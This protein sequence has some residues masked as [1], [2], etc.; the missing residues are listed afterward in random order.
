MSDTGNRSAPI[1]IMLT[2]VAVSVAAFFGFTLKKAKEKR[3]AETEVQA[4]KQEEILAQQETERRAAEKQAAQ[5]AE[6]ADAMR[7]RHLITLVEKATAR[8][9]QAV[10]ALFAPGDNPDHP[11]ATALILD[12]LFGELKYKP[13]PQAA[14]PAPSPN[15]STYILPIARAA[16]GE[17]RRHELGITFIPP[18]GTPPFFASLLLPSGLENELRDSA[19]QEKD[20]SAAIPQ[21]LSREPVQT[22][23]P[24]VATPA[25]IVA[26]RFV[27]AVI[28]LDYR[29]ARALCIADSLPAEKVAALCFVFED[30][31]IPPDTDTRIRV[32]AATGETAWAITKIHAPAWS[33]DLEFG[34]E[35]ERRSPLPD[36]AAP[37]DPGNPDTWGIAAI[38]LSEVLASYAS[39]TAAE[40]IPYTPV[41]E[42]P[43]GGQSLVLYFPYDSDEIH[44]RARRQLEIVASLLEGDADRKIRITGHADALGTIGYNEALSDE[45]AVEVRSFLVAA[46]IPGS[47]IVTE[48]AGELAPL[49]PNEKADGTDNPEGRARNRRAEIY[50]DF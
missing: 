15:T 1:L 5:A 42:N 13:D 14:R 16:N 12:R 29:T 41:V 30:A 33:A 9:R 20:V 2:V 4:R 46:G 23:K 11:R 31:Q 8:D 49:A 48:A 32:T 7:R 6:E 44:P 19:I 24:A 17:L 47:Q 39:R 35:I 3:Q 22:E 26:S 45:R 10:E 43:N 25:E 34:M 36:Q 37:D 27:D 40:E 50:L 21:E 28:R 18:L 38:N